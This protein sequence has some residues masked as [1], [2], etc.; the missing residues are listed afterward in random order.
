MKKSSDGIGTTAHTG[1]CDVWQILLFQNSD[2]EDFHITSLHEQSLDK[3]EGPT[4][5]TPKRG[6]KVN[7]SML[8][9]LRQ[10]HLWG[11]EYQFQLR[12][13]SCPIISI[14]KTLET[15]TLHIFLCPHVDITC[16]TKF[17]CRCSCRNTAGQLLFVQWH[18]YPC[19]AEGRSKNIVEFVWT[20]VGTTLEINLSSTE[21]SSVKLSANRVGRVSTWIT[22]QWRNQQNSDHPCIFKS[23]PIHR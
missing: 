1:K 13:N 14:R 4:A 6:F 3:G 9:R 11:A 22:S 17:G 2:D 19:L 23:L 20:K 10:P 8:Q 15:L 7:S 16:H 21:A 5:E 12:V 18:V